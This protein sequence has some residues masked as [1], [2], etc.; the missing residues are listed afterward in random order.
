M[1]RAS[2]RT[3]SCAKQS[4]TARSA[5]GAARGVLHSMAADVAGTDVAGTMRPASFSVFATWAPLRGKLSCRNST[6]PSRKS[7][8]SSTRRRC[9]SRQ[10]GLGWTPFFSI[11]CHRSHA[12]AVHLNALPDGLQVFVAFHALDRR[13]QQEP[14]MNKARLHESWHSSAFR[15]RCSGGDVHQRAASRPKP[16]S[17]LLS[18][19]AHSCPLPPRR[20]QPSETTHHGSPS[21]PPTSPLAAAHAGR[22]CLRCLRCRRCLPHAQPSAASPRRARHKA[23]ALEQ[24]RRAR[25]GCRGKAG[26]RAASRSRSLRLRQQRQAGW[27]QRAAAEQG[28]ARERAGRAGGRAG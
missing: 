17:V 19:P 15:S 24:Q 27:L 5:G 11:C 10:A 1:T 2:K 23:S 28:A 14:L 26:A 7:W 22:T 8:S 21:A 4:R 20:F 3:S 13:D 6:M 16:P 25:S 12:A 9:G 18:V